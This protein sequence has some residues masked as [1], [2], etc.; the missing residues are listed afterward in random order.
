MGLMSQNLHNLPFDSSILFEAVVCSLRISICPDEGL[1]HV[2]NPVLFPM[3]LY[4]I[5]RFDAY[6]TAALFAL[7]FLRFH[8]ASS[9]LLLSS[10]QIPLSQISLSS[11]NCLPL[12]LLPLRWGCPL[13]AGLILD[14]IYFPPS[15][16]SLC[17]IALAFPCSASYILSVLPSFLRRLNYALSL[18]FL[19][20]LRR[21]L[22]SAFLSLQVLHCSLGRFCSL[23]HT[24]WPLH[25]IL[26]SIDFLLS[27]H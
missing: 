19:P 9:L 23:V 13:Y 11:H 21:S 25:C 14:T 10:S 7:S 2:G 3:L 26:C 16:L 5:F 17:P 8:L 6:L 22:R 18:S 24:Y 12:S 20:I 27:P 1:L 15:P 4:S